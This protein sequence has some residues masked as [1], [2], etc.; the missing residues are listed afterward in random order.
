MV[1]LNV[2]KITLKEVQLNAIKGLAEPKTMKMFRLV[3][4]ISIQKEI[5]ASNHAHQRSLV[6]GHGALRDRS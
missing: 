1:Q 2:L 4:G 5:L 3:K 6:K